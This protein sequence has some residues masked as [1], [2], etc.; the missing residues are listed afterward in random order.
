VAHAD[1]HPAKFM[2]LQLVCPLRQFV[3]RFPMPVTATVP[4]PAL[5]PAQMPT[6]T[7]MAMPMRTRSS[8]SSLRS[9]SHG[10]FFVG[11]GVQ[12]IV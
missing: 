2:R 1:S 6:P 9:P 5:T 8:S 11:H 4:M 10:L 12:E 7:E 3:V